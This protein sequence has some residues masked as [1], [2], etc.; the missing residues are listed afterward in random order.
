MIDS[1]LPD[2]RQLDLRDTT[3]FVDVAHAVREALAEGHHD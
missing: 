3:A 1:P 2:E